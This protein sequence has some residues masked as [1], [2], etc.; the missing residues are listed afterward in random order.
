[1][2]ASKGLGTNATK[3]AGSSERR[4]LLGRSSGSEEN[5]GLT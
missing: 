3:E 1:M 2:E 5:L 4:E